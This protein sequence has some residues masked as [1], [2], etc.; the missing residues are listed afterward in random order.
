MTGASGLPSGVLGA[1]PCALLL[2]W[3]YSGLTQTAMRPGAAHQDGGLRVP[4][5]GSWL[6]SEGRAGR[7]PLT[8]IYWNYVGVSWQ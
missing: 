4:V 1:G 6:G 8:F 5:S 7:R 3:L 2:P